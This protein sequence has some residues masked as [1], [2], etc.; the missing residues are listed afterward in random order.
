MP[1][2]D[3]NSEP[4]SESASRSIEPTPLALRPFSE[5]LPDGLLRAREMA[6][7]SFRPLLVKYELTDQQW[8]VLRALSEADE[9]PQIAHLAEAAFL[10]APSLTRI[11]ANLENRKLIT[12]KAVAS[13][14]RRATIKLTKAGWD[15]F[16]E[17]AP[18]SEAIYL[19]IESAFG[20][21]RLKAL[22]DELA[23]LTKL[24]PPSPS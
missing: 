4:K 21:G 8:R 12:R 18:Q 17:I 23:E 6:M 2:A 22:L 9:P 19:R 20:K 10:R 5:S 3:F 11:L 7:S 15:L 14:N 16:N 1:Q 13:D 24:N